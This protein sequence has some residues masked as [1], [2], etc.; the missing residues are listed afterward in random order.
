[1]LSHGFD[2]S[3][4]GRDLD[5]AMMTYFAAQ[6]QEKQKLDCLSN[7]RSRLRLRVATE[8]V[9]VETLKDAF[10]KYIYI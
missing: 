1:M 9:S 8:K 4:G 3:L 2:R 7:A 6:F 10:F 5:N